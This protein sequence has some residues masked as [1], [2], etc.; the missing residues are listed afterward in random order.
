MRS[1]PILGLIALF[2]VGQRAALGQPIPPLPSGAWATSP[3]QR[4]LKTVPP[5]FDSAPVHLAAARNE[6]ESFQVIVSAADQQFAN[7]QIVASPLVGPAGEI[8]AENVRFYREH[9]IEITTPSYRS[10]AAPGWYPD[11]LIPFADPATGE[12]I[13]GARFDATPFNVEPY[14]NQGVWVDVYV[15]GDATSGDYQGTITVTGNDAVLGQ[16]S[17][18]LTVYDFTLPDSIAMRSWFGTWGLAGFLGLDPQSEEFA[19]IQDLYIDTLLEHRCVPSD[20]GRIWPDRTAEGGLDDTYTIDRLRTMIEEKHVNTLSAPFWYDGCLDQCMPYLHNLDGY[21]QDHGWGDLAIVYMKDEPNTAEDYALVREQATL[22]HENAPG[23]SR[24][25]TEQTLTQDPA[26]GDLYGSVD[27]WCP[28]WGLY[29][30]TTARQRQDLGE[31][32]WSYTALCQM[33]ER[34]PFWEIDFPPIVYRAP[35]WTSWHYGIKGFLYWSTVYWDVSDDVW[36]VPD[37]TAWGLHFWGE[38][39]LLYPG[40]EVG[41]EG[42]APSIRLKLIR[43]AMEDFEY[44]SLAARRAGKGAVDP[45]VEGIATSFT[46]WDRDPAAYYTARQQLAD[47][48]ETHLFSDVPSDHWAFDEIGACVDAGVVS[49]YRDGLYRPG[50][51]VSRAQM[52]VFIARARGWVGLEDDMT[53]AP[54]LFPDVPAGAW[55]GTA[56]QACLDNG[57]ATGYDDGTFRPDESVSRDQMAVFIARARGW[58]EI[59][60]DMAIARPLFPDVPAEF[61]AGSAIEACISNQVVEGY[62]D[63]LYRPRETVTRDQMAVFVAKAFQLAM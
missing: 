24:L 58:V 46:E 60:D 10:T 32:M 13:V 12:D 47:L 44:M 17:V 8:A 57:V 19:R 55:A 63:G 7:V 53:T 48:I 62:P 20:L 52:A 61:W 37:Y 59:G 41:T 33:D 50:H 18:A 43:E 22:L 38:G 25:C 15:P 21:L 5:A 45:I 16:I 9:Y 23:I 40:A 42:P 1:L 11:P 28:L 56:I 34:N 4:V 49:G 6:F 39:I 3:W 27:T 31:E 26:W 29:D 35:F 54:E 14:T 51:A 36:T 30:E 2:L